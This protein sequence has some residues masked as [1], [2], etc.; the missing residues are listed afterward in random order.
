MDHFSLPKLNL[1][2][3]TSSFLFLIFALIFPDQMEIVEVPLFIFFVALIGIP[4]GATDHLI[5]KYNQILN[6]KSFSMS[7]FLIP[8]LVGMGCFSI[9]WILFPGLSLLVFLLI[10][11]YHFGQSQFVFVNLPEKHL[12]KRIHYILWGSWVLSCII[13]LN[14]TM[15]EP[16]LANIIDI[17]SLWWKQLTENR[18]WLITGLTA[19]NGLLLIYFYMNKWIRF[20]NLIIESLSMLLLWLIA[21][22]TSLLISFMVYFCLWHGLKSIHL[23]IRL[24]QKVEKNYSISRFVKDAFPFSMISLVGIA[25]LIYATYYWNPSFSVYMMFFILVSIL[26]LPHFAFIN[27]FYDLFSGHSKPINPSSSPVN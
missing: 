18:G 6:G 16:I 26:T 5:Y 7:R 4:H 23:E 13:L 10:S 19:S 14:L 1:L 12:L 25:G 22:Y 2:I 27:R 17:Q 3:W 20:S 9:L 21:N 11:A 15:S 24:L 8:Y